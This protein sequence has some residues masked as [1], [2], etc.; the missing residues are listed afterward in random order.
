MTD[1]FDRLAE[2]IFEAS[3]RERRRGS[4]SSA[5]VLTQR[6]VRAQARAALEALRDPSPAMVA[7]GE[8]Y[9]VRECQISEAALWRAMVDAAMGR[10]AMGHA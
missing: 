6:M 2:A 4:L 10:S 8:E 3:R 1:I 7:A 5:P 9:L